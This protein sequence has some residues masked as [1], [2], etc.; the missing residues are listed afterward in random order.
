MDIKE[1]QDRQTAGYT[2]EQQSTNRNNT[3][4]RGIGTSSNSG[5]QNWDTLC[6]ETKSRRKKIRHSKSERGR[7]V[8]ATKRHCL[9]SFVNQIL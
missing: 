8:G 4:A 2:T 7:E 9:K 5:P 3:R 6:L 1:I